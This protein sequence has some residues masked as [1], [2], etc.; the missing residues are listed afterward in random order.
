MIVP[1]TDNSGE[2]STPRASA[3]IESSSLDSDFSGSDVIQTLSDL[4]LISQ[5]G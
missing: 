4:G 3:S 1:K 5:K 2:F